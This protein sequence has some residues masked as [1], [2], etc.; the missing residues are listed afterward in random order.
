VEALVGFIGWSSFAHVA[1]RRYWC[2]KLSTVFALFRGV[3][4]DSVAMSAPP[5]CC[6]R[7]M[8]KNGDKNQCHKFPFYANHIIFLILYVLRPVLMDILKPQL[9][10]KKARQDKKVAF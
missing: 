6:K 8:K 4:V 3:L 9:K 5:H 1:L 10:K 2:F 7:V